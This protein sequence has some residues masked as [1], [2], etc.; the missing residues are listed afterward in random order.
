MLD[1]KK[2]KILP[3]PPEPFL[4]PTYFAAKE[5]TDYGIR[6]AGPVYSGSDGN[7]YSIDP[8]TRTRKRV[9]PTSGGYIAQS[10]GP[11]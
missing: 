11:Y 9:T 5:F 7:L 10:R 2:K 1:D 4:S 3:P 6:D 8:L